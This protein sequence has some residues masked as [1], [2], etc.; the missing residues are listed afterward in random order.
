MY[1]HVVSVEHSVAKP[2]PALGDAQMSPLFH[3]V[4]AWCPLLHLFGYVYTRRE[5]GN[6]L[7][8]AN[9]TVGGV[10]GSDAL[11][12]RSICAHIHGVY[13]YFMVL[14]HDPSVSAMQFGAQLEAVAIRVLKPS[15]S[16]APP[17]Q[18]QLLHHVEV[19]RRLPFYGYHA[20]HKTFFKV[21]VI[22]PEV[23]SRLVQLLSQTTEVGG[24]RWQTYEAHTPYHFQFMVDY[25]MKGMAPFC[26]PACTARSPVPTEVQ[27]TQAQANLHI[28]AVMPQGEPL[29]LTRAEL[30]VDVK[31]PVLQRQECPVESGENLF[32]VRRSVR[33]YFAEHGVDD[34]LRCGAGSDMADRTCTVCDVQS[35]DSAVSVMRQRALTHL[36][37]RADAVVAETSSHI[38]STPRDDVE[39]PTNFSLH[40]GKLSDQL[41]LRLMEEMHEDNAKTTRFALSFSSSSSSSSSS[42]LSVPSIEEAIGEAGE[43]SLPSSEGGACLQ[44]APANTDTSLVIGD[45]IVL[46]GVSVDGI[47]PQTPSVAKITAM[48]TQTVRLRWYM[49]LRETHLADT[50]EELERSGR[51]LARRVPDASGVAAALEEELLLGDVEDENPI[52]VLRQAVRVAVCHAYCAPTTPALLCRYN[53]HVSEQRLSAIAP[54]RSEEFVALPAALATPTSGAAGVSGAVDEDE[55]LLTSSSSSSSFSSS[56][57]FSSPS[58]CVVVAERRDV[59]PLFFSRP[60]TH[61]DG[62][63]IQTPVR[64]S[65]P[66]VMQQASQSQL[67]LMLSCIGSSP[68]AAAVVYSVAS[69]PDASDAGAKEELSSSLSLEC[70]NPSHAAF[71][72]GWRETTSRLHPCHFMGDISRN[73]RWTYDRHRR[74]V[75]SAASWPLATP[76]S[77]ASSCPAFAAVSTR[78]GMPTSTMGM[79]QARP[80]VPLPSHVAP[81]PWTSPSHQHASASKAKWQPYPS[82]NVS[83]SP[84][85]NTYVTC[86]LRV[87]YVEVLVHRQSGNQNVVQEELLAVALGRTSSFAESIGVRLFC[88]CPSTMTI[89]RLQQPFSGVVDVVPLPSELHLLQRVRREVCSYD[90]DVLLSW[91]GCKYGVGLLALRYRIVLQRSLARDV[92]RLSIHDMSDDASEEEDEALLLLSSSSLSAGDEDVAVPETAGASSA[93]AVPQPGAGGMVKR[94]SRRF[95]GGVRVPGRVVVDLGKQLCKELRLPSHTLQMVH[96]K[97]F[98]RSLPYFTDI[99]LAEMYTSSS[100]DMRRV[101][102]TVLLTRVVTPH[103]VAQHLNF[104]TRTAEFARMYGI[105]FYEVLSRGSQY[106]VEATL[107]RM[108]RPIGYTMLSPSPEEVHRQPRLVSMPLIMQPRSGFYKDDPVVVLDFRSL[109][110]SIIIAYNLCYSTCLGRVSRCRHSRLGVLASYKQADSVLLQLLAEDDACPTSRRVIF[111]PNGCMFLSPRDTQR[112]APANA[113]SSARHTVSST[114]GFEA[115][116]T[117]VRGQVHATRP[118]TAA[119]SH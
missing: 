9:A 30:E 13:P 48:D 108:A 6:G 100:D 53:Y 43:R 73:F 95:G 42:L 32:S 3:R 85:R 77:T 55:E 87:M 107:H 68:S 63:H 62:D 59:T 22:D 105:L 57:L 26:I 19:V 114:G 111:A 24:R 21:S 115:C 104:Y 96:Q 83:S 93:A 34:A 31:A 119:D 103:R 5:G 8:E 1:L 37:A 16:T 81:S 54:T 65:V 90:P 23:V 11:Q 82:S 40:A 78:R 10:R 84:G 117:A 25:G 20:K 109:Y 94:L 44:E 12:Q 38:S 79:I 17:L 102:L 7:D 47:I 18:L 98:R 29:R 86:E 76:V 101:A 52:A 14:R 69:Q 15:P 56:S 36:R 88:V 118:P 66:S 58:S 4:S 33:Q 35:S 45:S 49:T 70:V 28:T 2:D 97:L 110:P 61:D 74:V 51:W 41:T 64:R 75:V 113:A 89:R 46:C 99:A 112:G 60:S 72:Q 91:E 106:R 80:S 39:T 27:P 67:A 92:A 116:G 71:L 50:Q